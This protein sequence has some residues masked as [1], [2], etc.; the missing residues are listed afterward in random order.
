MPNV[1]I[2][3][4]N[5]GTDVSLAFQ[6]DRGDS[7]T[8]DQLG[9]LM[10]FDS[11]SQDVDSSITPI[12]GGG[13]PIHQTLWNGITGNMS[14]TRVGPAFQQMFMDLMNAYFTAGVITQFTISVNVRNRNG[15][16]DEYLYTGVQFT[17]PRFGNFRSTKEVDLRVGFKASK[18]QVNGSAT[19]FLTNVAGAA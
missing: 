4:Y 18:M 12:T 19:A 6:D 3:G 5:V 11:D 1:T 8:G 17:R 7:F 13:V 9:Y 14:F 16:I 2:N 10:E 15:N